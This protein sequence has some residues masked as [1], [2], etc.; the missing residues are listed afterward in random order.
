[1]YFNTP[2]VPSEVNTDKQNKTNEKQKNQAKYNIMDNI[3]THKNKNYL[4][5]MYVGVFSFGPFPVV[6][7]I[8][9]FQFPNYFKIHIDIMKSMPLYSDK[10]DILKHYIVRLIVGCLTYIYYL[11]PP[12]PHREHPLLDVNLTMTT[13]TK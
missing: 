7:P 8:L 10:Q 1:M 13:D 4:R 2:R 5:R 9:N 6:V 11:P 12:K 3:N